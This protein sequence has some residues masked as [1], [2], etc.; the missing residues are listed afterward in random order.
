MSIK[1]ILS[2]AFGILGLMIILLFSASLFS[3][4][5]TQVST[6]QLIHDHEVSRGLTAIATN[7]QLLQRLEKQ[8]LIAIDSGESQLDLEKWTDTKTKIFGIFDMMERDLPMCG[9]AELVPVIQQWRA[10]LTTYESEF[11]KLNDKVLSS[12]IS[13]ITGGV[14]FLSLADQNFELL[15]ADIEFQ[16]NELF[17]SAKQHADVAQ[18]FNF[19][20][21]VVIAVISF[22]SMIIVI[23]SFGRV[24]RAISF[25]IVQLTEL[26]TLISKGQANDKVKV[27]GSPEIVELSKSV[28]RLRVAS[29]GLMQRYQASKAQYDNL[30][31]KILEAKK[32][33]K[34]RT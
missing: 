32:R 34:E 33:S 21:L 1:Q 18:K 30:R 9:L 11:L 7:A 3:S 16:I 24:P 29:N 19:I 8:Y 15:L 2:I 10:N 20:F 25:P 13:T 6:T 5:K 31:N 4:Y 27:H 23:I 17:S 28:D 12:E 22:F 26:T 14:E